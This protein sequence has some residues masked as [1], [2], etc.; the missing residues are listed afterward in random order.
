MAR[1]IK[2]GVVRQAVERHAVVGRKGADPR[3]PELDHMAVA[4]ERAAEVARD[5]AHVGALAAFG[6]EHGRV[7][8]GLDE[9]EPIDVDRPRG[10]LEGLAVAGEIIGARAVDLDGGKGRRR[11]LDQAD[12][13]RQQPPRSRPGVG[14]LS[15][16]A[17][18][19]PSASSVALSSPQRTRNR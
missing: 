11:L 15:E 12:E 10:D 13:A 14:R 3:A 4:A 17:T 9:R 7:A 16:R 6:L 2:L 18:I 19:S 5:R 1:A 8:V